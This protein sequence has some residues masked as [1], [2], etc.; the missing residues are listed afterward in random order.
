MGGRTTACILRLARGDQRLDVPPLAGAL[1]EVGSRL[2]AHL[3]D[4]ASAQAAIA[5]AVPGAVLPP[6]PLPVGSTPPP[7]PDFHIKPTRDA[8]PK[9]DPEQLHSGLVRALGQAHDDG[10]PMRR[11]LSEADLW[12]ESFIR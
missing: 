8:N 2:A 12:A 9:M 3:R 1:E 6:P 5:S 11:V 4:L 7:P 10:S